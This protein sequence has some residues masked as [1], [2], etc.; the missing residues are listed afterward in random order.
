MK[1]SAVFVSALPYSWSRDEGECSFNSSALQ[2]VGGGMK[3]CAVFVSTLPSVGA[4]RKESAVFVS[5]LPSV[6]AGRKESAVFVSAL[7]NSWSRDEGEYSVCV[8]APE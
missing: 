3:E 7:P 4:G 5:A 2:I 1:E 6:G 8:S